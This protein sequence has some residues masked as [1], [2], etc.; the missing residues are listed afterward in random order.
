MRH[1]A[2]FCNLGAEGTGQLRLRCYSCHLFLWLANISLK[3][4]TLYHKEASDGPWLKSILFC[5]LCVYV[6]VRCY[7]DNQEIEVRVLS[8][9]AKSLHFH[10]GRLIIVHA[11]CPEIATEPSPVLLSIK[12]CGINNRSQKT[13]H[14]KKILAQ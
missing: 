6:Y 1:G 5:F 9:F 8:L 2:G 10:Q 7:K 13:S 3:F 11:S 4:P 12:M 14:C